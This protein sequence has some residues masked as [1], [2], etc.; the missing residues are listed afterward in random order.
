MVCGLHHVDTE[1]VSVSQ[2][3]CE[4]PIVFVGQFQAFEKVLKD[5]NNLEKRR[6]I[7]GEMVAGTTGS[8]FLPRFQK[9]QV[10]LHEIQARM[11]KSSIEA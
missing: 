6:E 3:R 9:D 7:D 5:F 1:S 8:F 10:L 4:D 11:F 2:V